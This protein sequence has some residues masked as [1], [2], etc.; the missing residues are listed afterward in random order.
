LLDVEDAAVE[1]LAVAGFDPD[2]GARA[3]KRTIERDVVGRLAGLFATIPLGQPVFVRIR[4]Q[5]TGV[6][7]EATPLRFATFEAGRGLPGPVDA[8][9]LAALLDALPAVTFR[10]TA[11]P[12]GV[13]IEGREVQELRARIQDALLALAPEQADPEVPAHQL[14]RLTRGRNRG[15]W[16]RRYRQWEAITSFVSVRQFLTEGD[17]GEAWESA[18]D[19]GLLDPVLLGFLE[20]KHLAGGTGS[21]RLRMTPITSAAPRGRDLEPYVRAL[22]A[23]IHALW[24]DNHAWRRRE[25]GWVPVSEGLPSGREPL[26]WQVRGALAA[27]ILAAE[28]GLHVWYPPDAPPFGLAV[29]LFED[30]PPADLPVSPHLPILRLHVPRVGGTERHRVEDLRSGE[31]FESAAAEDLTLLSWWWRHFAETTDG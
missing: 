26:T 1:N 20:A 8:E 29:E 27:E 12:H 24:P 22:A 25:R 7:A 6:D 21:V 31:V 9:R 23:G 5:G 28:V 15:R 19:L 16:S 30:G 10:A 11:T 18:P 3:L 4:A 17:P 13:A 14:Q 2:L